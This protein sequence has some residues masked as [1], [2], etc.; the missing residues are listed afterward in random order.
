[1]GS[2]IGKGF[3]FEIPINII[4]DL[5]LKGNIMLGFYRNL[6]IVQSRK[7]GI[8]GTGAIIQDPKRKVEFMRK[9]HACVNM[10]T[11]QCNLR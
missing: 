10:L 4:F 9:M 11:Q 1:M 2:K 5:H 8:V 7:S 3:I 6:S